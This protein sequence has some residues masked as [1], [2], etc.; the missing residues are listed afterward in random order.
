MTNDDRTQLP[1]YRQFRVKKYVA[2]YILKEFKGGEALR[3]WEV[4]AHDRD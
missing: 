2:V 3:G 1:D 4:Q